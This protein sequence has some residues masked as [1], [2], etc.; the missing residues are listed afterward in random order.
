M[1]YGNDIAAAYRR[2]G[3]YAGRILKGEKPA[4]LPVDQATDFEFV[5]NLKTAKSLRLDVP[6]SL[7]SRANEIIE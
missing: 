1:S 3:L 6:P 5:I 7:S 4:D 2:A